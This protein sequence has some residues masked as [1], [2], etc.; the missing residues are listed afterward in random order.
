MQCAT[1]TSTNQSDGGDY[2]CVLFYKTY[3]SV[4][5]KVCLEMGLKC[6][7]ST[8]A[9]SVLSVTPIGS[10]IPELKSSRHS[11]KR[12]SLD[13]IRIKISTFVFLHTYFK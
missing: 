13:A 2:H 9:P 8:P 7:R 5:T 12:V 1:V 10:E 6:G 11:T 3:K 4:T